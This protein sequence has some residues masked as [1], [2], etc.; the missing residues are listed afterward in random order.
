MKY[1]LTKSRLSIAFALTFV[2]I[3]LAQ[4][5]PAQIAR[6]SPAAFRELPTNLV[7]ELQRRGCTIPQETWSGRRNNVIKGQFKKP[8]Q[9]DWAVL[10][11]LKGVST[12]LVFWNAS[13]KNPDA[14][15]PAKD[16]DSN[17][18]RGI[19]AVGKDF[20][21]RQYRQYRAYGGPKPPPIDHQGIEDASEKASIVW[22]FYESQWLQLTGAD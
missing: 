10:C 16:P 18:Q 21:M 4:S 3:S 15:A 9:M 14:I 2:T 8:G 1:T 20:I 19:R 6:L 7:E 22:Y 17:N 13:E 12:I 5:S 11:S